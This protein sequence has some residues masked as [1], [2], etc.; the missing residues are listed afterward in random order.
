M[1]EGSRMSNGTRFHPTRMTMRI[2]GGPR[3]I[4]DRTNAVARG[5]HHIMQFVFAPAP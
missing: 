1:G 3:N 4:F 5:P 2:L